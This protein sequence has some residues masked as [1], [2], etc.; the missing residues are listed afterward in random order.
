MNMRKTRPIVIAGCAAILLAAV[1][2]E[3]S[4]GQAFDPPP[5]GWT[6]VFEGDSADP[7]SGAANAFDALDGSW[8]YDNGSDAWDATAI[9]TGSPGGVSALTE[10]DVNYIRI[11][12]TGDPRDYAMPDP[13]NRKI[14]LGHDITAEGALNTILDDGVTISFRA[15]VPTTQ[16]PLD[17]QH[18]DGGTSPAPWLTTGDGYVTHD[19]GKGNF[20]IR[21]EG[22]EG[23]VSEAAIAFALAGDPEVSEFGV[24]SPGLVMNNLNGTEPSGDVDI[25]G[26]EPGERNLRPIDVTDWHEFWIVIEAGGTG[27]HQV[28]VWVDGAPVPSPFDVTA[29]TGDDFGDLNYIAMGAGATP[30]Q[31]AVDIDFFAWRA[32]KFIPGLVPGDV[33]G[34][35]QVDLADLEIIRMNYFNTDVGLPQ[36]DVNLD[37]VV[38]FQDYRVW[39]ENRTDL[40]AGTSVPEPATLSLV[41]LGVVALFGRRRRH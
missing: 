4:P 7:G 38:D 36:G 20:T 13:S 32:G 27:T 29:G 14:Y 17:D 3:R 41:L 35:D 30:Q 37:G 22:I 16:T 28:T 19:G 31:G 2:A 9:G 18:S 25:Q 1:A 23:E 11:Q 40:P 21:Q 5:G 33:T 6:Y 8:S 24:A 10:G 34:D 15:R 26:D 12:E 39:T